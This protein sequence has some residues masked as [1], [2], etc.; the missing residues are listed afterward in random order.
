MQLAKS[1]DEEEATDHLE[2]RS[3]MYNVDS[4]VGNES[5]EDA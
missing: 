5:Y 2:K 3:C 1:E 4:L